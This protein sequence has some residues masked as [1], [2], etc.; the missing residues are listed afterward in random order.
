[1]VKISF[2]KRSWGFQIKTEHWTHIPFCSL[3]DTIWTGVKVLLFCFVFCKKPQVWENEEDTI[4]E[5][6][7]SW[8]ADGEVAS[9]CWKPN[10]SQHAKANKTNQILQKSGTHYSCNSR[11]AGEGWRG[12]NKE[13]Q[14]KASKKSRWLPISAPWVTPHSRMQGIQPSSTPLKK[15]GLFPEECD[16]EDMGLSMMKAEAPD[17]SPVSTS[18]QEFGRVWRTQ[19]GKKL[20]ISTFRVPPKKSSPTALYL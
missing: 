11:R 7:L 2:K 5:N 19:S 6:T 8:E 16:A 3:L 9:A 17:C 18:R 20:K 1:M 13:N 4:K 15:E 10:L 14:L 12:P